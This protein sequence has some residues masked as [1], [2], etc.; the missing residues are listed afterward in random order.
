MRHSEHSKL[1][2]LSGLRKPIVYDYLYTH[3]WFISH[4]RPILLPSPARLTSANNAKQNDLVTKDS[5]DNN[6]SI[7]PG[8]A[9][10]A[11]VETGAERDFASH[12]SKRD[13]IYN[14]SLIC[15]CKVSLFAI[16][17]L[18]ET[19][20]LQRRPLPRV[21]ASPIRPVILGS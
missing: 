6:G 1:I 5:L 4:L 21:A 8:L 20:Y 10:S 2:Q 15:S 16:E 7:N 11:S 14:Q 19:S 17:G 13:F 3:F 18:A 12:D 9:V